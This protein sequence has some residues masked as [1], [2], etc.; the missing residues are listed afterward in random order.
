MSGLPFTVFPKQMSPSCT[1]SIR[2]PLTVQFG[3]TSG[4]KVLVGLRVL[5]GVL[6]FVKVAVAVLLAVFVRVGVLLA[7]LVSDLVEVL[8]DVAVFVAV[9]TSFDFAV[10][11]FR[12]EPS[13]SRVIS[14]FTNTTK[15]NNTNNVLPISLSFHEMHIL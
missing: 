5:V 4:A 3:N 13:T 6:E 1:K 2:T 7:V 14:K 10:G 8:V 15:T 9:A 11:V 12:I